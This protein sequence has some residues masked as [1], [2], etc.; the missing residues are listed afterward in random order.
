MQLRATSLFLTA[1]P[2][3][4]APAA[5]QSVWTIDQSGNVT[6]H[7][8]P[9]SGP[10]SYP[11][12][13]LL[14]F[15][16]YVTPGIC[17]TPA[18][19]GATS[20]GDM[21]ID[22]PA[23]ELWITDGV[24][25]AR[26]QNFGTPVVT[27]IDIS[28][29]FGAPVTGLDW[30]PGQGVLWVTDG[31]SAAAVSLNFLDPCYAPVTGTTFALPLPTGSPATALSHD[32]LTD[33][34]WVV[35]DGGY[36]TQV[37]KTGALGPLGSVQVSTTSGCGLAPSLRGVAVDT[38]GPAGRVYV[39]DSVTVAVVDA[40]AGGIQAAPTFYA[41]QTC[42]QPPS[43]PL[44]GMA[45]SPSAATFG[46]P[47]GALFPVIGHSGLS[48]VPNPSL[49]IN[50]AGANENELAFLVL[51]NDFSCPALTVLGVPFHLGAGGPLIT[52]AS[53]V[54]DATG[55]AALPLPLGVGTPIGNTVF[56]Q[57]GLIDPST[58][59]PSSTRGMALTTSLP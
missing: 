21:G 6:L 55:F 27:G 44:Q 25:A 35:D 16:S 5:A 53:A 10:C 12:G 29:V 15:Y 3:L 26:Y 49:T 8:G 42:Y 40:A 9:A 41:P 43:V 51:S 13:P 14:S 50:V 33:S 46:S 4:A 1:L 38:A 11:L 54:I 58:F 17:A 37:T 19:T 30:D 39:T 7:N 45:I 28:S 57:W 34:L 32:P 2:L 48:I 18:A 56:L 59:V 20:A 36:L 47:S 23:N 52:V 24:T 31:A 22:R